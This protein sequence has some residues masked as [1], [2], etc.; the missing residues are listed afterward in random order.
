[1]T[2]N[3]RALQIHLHMADTAILFLS[4]S[5][6]SFCYCG[7]DPNSQFPLAQKWHFEYA[8]CLI[9]LLLMIKDKIWT[10]FRLMIMVHHKSPFRLWSICTWIIIKMYHLVQSTIDLVIHQNGHF[11]KNKGSPCIVVI[12]MMSLVIFW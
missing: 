8:I 3:V 4:L 7:F 5:F 10:C 2:L 1:M 6:P 9:C 11:S 12:F